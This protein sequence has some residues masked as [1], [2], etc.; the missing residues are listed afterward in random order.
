MKSKN[1]LLTLFFTC[2]TLVAV[3]QSK[4]AHPSHFYNYLGKTASWID[5]EVRA[6]YDLKIE[7]NKI[8]KDSVRLSV[9][10]SL[11]DIKVTFYLVDD[12]CDYISFDDYSLDSNRV[13]S[14]FTQWCSDVTDHFKFISEEYERYPM[15]MDMSSDVVFYI[16]E[17]Q[18][19]ET[20][21]RY[22]LFSGFIRNDQLLTSL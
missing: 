17:D 15:F 2:M 18:N 12:A 13:R 19:L 22:F 16:P 20:G 7:K 6:S 9:Y 10:N 11:S 5:R 1:T 3:S 14:Y 8:S 21:L 4:P